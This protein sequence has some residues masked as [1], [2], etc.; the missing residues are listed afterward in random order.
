MQND[1]SGEAM[2]EEYEASQSVSLG[3]KL[4]I[5]ISDKENKENEKVNNADQGGSGTMGE[6]RQK[7][8]MTYLFWTEP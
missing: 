2:E 5:A 1:R 7:T 3:T 4:G 6:L 8:W